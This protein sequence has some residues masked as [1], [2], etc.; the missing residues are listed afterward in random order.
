M[1]GER[2]ALALRTGSHAEAQGP[3]RRLPGAAIFPDVTAQLSAPGVAM[4]C[5]AARSSA[6]RCRGPDPLARP[7][8]R[9]SGA[10]P[11][12]PPSV[13]TPRP[14]GGESKGVAARLGTQMPGAGGGSGRPLRFKPEDD[15]CWAE[16]W[17]QC[18]AGQTWSFT[19]RIPKALCG[20]KQ[21]VSA[22]N[23]HGRQW[24]S[25]GLELCFGNC[26]T[27]FLQCLKTEN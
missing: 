16:S 1:A 4:T 26:V 22:Q 27:Y 12:G 19:W 5:G 9:A 18:V 23:A 10:R 14:A 24:H 25:E 7:A 3:R 21:V 13:E 15:H 20:M 2:P 8:A 6:G 17:G 11:P